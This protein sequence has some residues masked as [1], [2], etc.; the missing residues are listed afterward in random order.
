MCDGPVSD[1]YLLLVENPA[2]VHLFDKILTC[3][4]DLRND[5]VEGLKDNGEYYLMFEHE[6]TPELLDKFSRN[7]E[8]ALHFYYDLLK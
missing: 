3:C 4:R 6:L 8:E 2:A 1:F 5:V 7:F